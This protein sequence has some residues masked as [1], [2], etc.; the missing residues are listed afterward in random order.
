MTQGVQTDDIQV[1]RKNALTDQWEPRELSGP[2]DLETLRITGLNHFCWRCPKK[3]GTPRLGEK[4][5]RANV[6]WGLSYLEAGARS[7]K[8]QE[9]P[10]RR[11]IE[12]SD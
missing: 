2:M 12:Y 6:H 7:K 4:A 11:P 1:H 10:T 9:S 3:A 5:P 8:C